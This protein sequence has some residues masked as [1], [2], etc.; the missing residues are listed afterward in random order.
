MVGVCGYSG[1]RG[2]WGPVVFVVHVATSCGYNGYMGK[3][4]VVRLR[5]TGS[6]ADRWVEAAWVE[7]VSLSEWLRQAANARVSG[8]E[9]VQVSPP[10]REPA[11]KQAIAEAAAGLR[12]E[13]NQDLEK[14]DPVEQARRKLEAP[15]PKSA[16]ELARAAAALAEGKGKEVTPDWR[17]K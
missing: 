3:E 5:V 15:K 17:K 1:Y 14:P 16:A 9:G 6:E 4:R 10:A 8:R 11:E 2:V 7:R 12:R 13:M